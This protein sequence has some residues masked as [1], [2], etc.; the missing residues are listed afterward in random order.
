MIKSLGP[1]GLLGAIVILLIAVGIA[2]I[3]RKLGITADL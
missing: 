2:Y 1:L 3:L